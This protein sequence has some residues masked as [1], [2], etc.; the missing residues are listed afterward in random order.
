MTPLR[1]ALRL[2][3]LPFLLTSTLSA[4]TDFRILFDTDNNPATG[5][6][7]YGMNGVERVVTTT[8]DTSGSTPRVSSIQSQVCSGGSLGGVVALET[9]G[10]PAGFDAATGVYTV[11]TRVLYSLFGDPVPTRMRLGFVAISGSQTATVLTDDNGNPFLFPQS[12]VRR[13]AVGTPGHTFVLDGQAGDWMAMPPLSFGDFDNGPNLARFLGIFAGA[14][15][16]GFYFRFDFQS[17]SGAPTARND[18]YSTPAGT[19]LSVTAPGVMSNDTD[20]NNRA[21]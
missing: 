13:R 17:H 5:C 21:L 18:S 16:D 2:A 6:A 11:E 19:P 14:G 15:A 20:P 9:L 12:P 4:S 7:V 10:W 8:L 1:N 3:V